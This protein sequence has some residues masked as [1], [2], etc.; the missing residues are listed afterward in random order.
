MQLCLWTTTDA[1]AE[2]VAAGRDHP[3]GGF[4]CP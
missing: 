1:S 4:M 2:N 3:A